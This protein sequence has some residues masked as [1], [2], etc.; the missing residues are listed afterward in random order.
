[1]LVFESRGVASRH[2]G[3]EELASGLTLFM[4]VGASSFLSGTSL[5]ASV[6]GVEGVVE[7]LSSTGGKVEALPGTGSS[8][9]GGFVRARLD[10]RN[11]PI[12]GGR[13]RRYVSTQSDRR[14][15]MGVEEYLVIPTG[16]ISMY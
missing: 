1:M 14:A 8:T 12:K 5:G 11:G 15:E 3:F 4:G 9:L 6:T 7:L 2:T 13:G 10:F 16:A